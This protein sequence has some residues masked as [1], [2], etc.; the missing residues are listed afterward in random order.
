[1]LIW[2]FFFE[3]KE[4]GFRFALKNMEFRFNNQPMKTIFNHG[5]L[6]LAINI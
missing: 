6:A 2:V 5:L 1:M 4:S 3:L